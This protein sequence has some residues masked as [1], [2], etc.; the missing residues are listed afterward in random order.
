ML[1]PSCYFLPLVFIAEIAVVWWWWL[2]IIA[3]CA[4]V[5]NSDYSISICQEAALGEC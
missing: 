5:F 3:G 1:V 4:A 2:A